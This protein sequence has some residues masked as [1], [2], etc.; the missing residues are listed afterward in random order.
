[1]L[2][3]APAFAYVLVAGALSDRFGRKP[4]LLL[5]MVGSILEMVA[6]TLG[7]WLF[8][9]VPLW[10]FHLT[11]LNELTGGYALFFLGVYG[12]GSNST[13]QDKRATRLA[14]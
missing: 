7:Y 12:F 6:F 3:M 2:G 14:R 1:M 8:Y 13:R 9:R 4:L 5:P 11:A 10:F